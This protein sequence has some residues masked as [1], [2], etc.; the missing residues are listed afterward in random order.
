MA[1]LTPEQYHEP[2]YDR[3]SELRE[4]DLHIES[5]L[6][7]D[8][9]EEERQFNKKWLKD[10]LIEYGKALIDNRFRRLP[11]DSIFEQKAFLEEFRDVILT[12]LAKA[13]NQE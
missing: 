10:K 9:S 7:D 3:E 6:R 13:A 8:A 5:F 4:I 12:A 11:K 1:I 2:R